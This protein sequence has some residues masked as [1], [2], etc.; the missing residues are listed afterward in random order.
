MRYLRFYLCGDVLSIPFTWDF[1]L[2]RLC[3]IKSSW[4]WLSS[5][6]SLYLG[7]SLAS[8]VIQHSHAFTGRY[9]QFPLLGIFPCIFLLCS[10]KNAV[11]QRLSIP[12]TW[13]FPLHRIWTRV[14]NVAEP[15]SFNSLYLGFSLASWSRGL[16][17]DVLAVLLSIPFTWDFPLHHAKGR[18]E[19]LS[20]NWTFQFPLL[21]IFPCI[22]CA[23]G[24]SALLVFSLSIPFTWDF[25]L[26][27]V[28]LLAA[29]GILALDFQFPL[30]GIFPCIIRRIIASR[31]RRHSLSIPFT[32]DFPLHQWSKCRQ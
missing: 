30:L 1:P 21:G 28:E 7:F 8:N 16:L 14:V 22:T 6:N 18:T 13:D 11:V 2:H 25:P 5:F 24:R 29:I 31:W 23:C 32:W 10:G 4:S 19:M 20:H 9:F 26:H 12:F 3:N 27:L 17:L 15:K